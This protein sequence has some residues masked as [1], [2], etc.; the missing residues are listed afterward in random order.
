MLEQG[1]YSADVDC[2]QVRQRI[3]SAEATAPSTSE[4]CTVLFH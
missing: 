2:L 4:M 3:C 1:A